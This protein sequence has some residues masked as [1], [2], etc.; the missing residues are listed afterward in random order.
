MFGIL[1]LVPRPAAFAIPM[2]ENPFY[3]VAITLIGV[4]LT[5][6][7]YAVTIVVA[8]ILATVRT[9]AQFIEAALA[10]ISRSIQRSWTCASTKPQRVS[11]GDVGVVDDWLD[12]P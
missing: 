9:I 3:F 5:F 8:A 6:A 11:R 7:S 1:L 12:G 10:G 4:V 2:S